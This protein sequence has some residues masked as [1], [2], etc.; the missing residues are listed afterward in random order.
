MTYEYR[1]FRNTQELRNHLET[2]GFEGDFESDIF[3]FEDGVYDIEDVA[4]IWDTF[5]IVIKMIM[6]EEYEWSPFKY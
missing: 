5:P 4:L 2:Y 1:R 3:S 6:W